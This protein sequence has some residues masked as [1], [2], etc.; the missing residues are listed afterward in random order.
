MDMLQAVV[1][2]RRTYSNAGCSHD[3]PFAQLIL[4]L[5]VERRAWNEAPFLDPMKEPKIWRIDA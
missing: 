3:H 2:E 5:T 1:G 4:P